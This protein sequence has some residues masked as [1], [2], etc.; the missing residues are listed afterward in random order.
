MTKKPL[1]KLLQAL[2][3]SIL[4][5]KMKRKRRYDFSDEGIDALIAVGKSPARLLHSMLRKTSGGC[6]LDALIVSG[7]YKDFDYDKRQNF[8]RDRKKLEDIGFIYR[9]GN[10]YI[11][12]H[13]LVN[14]THRRQLDWFML[15]L[16]V[17]QKTPVFKTNKIPTAPVENT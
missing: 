5:D 1:P 12:S 10:D 14:Y 8:H 7:D 6:E 4:H 9:D 17:K 15:K 11:I 2:S 16:G 3:T 13:D